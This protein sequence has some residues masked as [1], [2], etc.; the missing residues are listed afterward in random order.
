MEV[1]QT[2]R[3]IAK[4]ILT[5]LKKEGLDKYSLEGMENAFISTYEIVREDE[6]HS[7]TVSWSCKKN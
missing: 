2:A 7:Y 5:E 4:S 6:S 3:F 1:A